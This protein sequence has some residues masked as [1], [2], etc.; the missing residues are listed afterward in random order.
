MSTAL[1]L[2]ALE[3]ALWARGR[4]EG[5]V[6]PSDRGSQYLSIR[7]T[8]RLAEAGIQNSVGSTGESYDNALA[9]SIIGL[10]KTES[11]RKPGPWKSIDSLELATLQWVDWDNHRR[12][13]GPI[14]DLPPAAFEQA[15]YESAVAA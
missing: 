9:E 5:L 13:L 4:S 12:W 11:L 6:H 2:D 7:Y 15:Y 3:P 14:G 10:F 8:E 1:V